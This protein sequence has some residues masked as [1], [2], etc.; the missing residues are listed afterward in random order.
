MALQFGVCY[1]GGD[2]EYVRL[3]RWPFTIGRDSR[4]DLCLA[5]SAHISRR[6]ARVIRVG[7][8][9]QLIAHGRN[10]TYLNG[11]RIPPEVP[12]EIQ[13]GDTIELPDYV[14]NV[15]DTAQS[16]TISATINVQAVSNTTIIIRR[17]ASALG[18]RKWTLDGIFD[19]LQVGRGR[20]VWIRHHQVELYLSKRLSQQ[21]LNERLELFDDLLTRLDPQQLKI[22][23]I[24]PTQ[25]R[26][27][28]S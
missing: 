18:A 21:Q 10:S 20:E 24:D 11:E 6:H 15:R 27:I 3:R 19:W 7:D 26:A 16:N 12:V 28:H 2:Y 14:L 13:A 1:A 5:N 8:T 17:I 4:S 9:Y 22:E 23:I 25:P